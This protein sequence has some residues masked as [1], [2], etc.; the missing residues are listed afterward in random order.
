MYVTVNGGSLWQRR[1]NGLP[2]AVGTLPRSAII[3]YGSSTEFFVGLG[4][5]TNTGIG[6]FRTT[7]QG[8]SW[9]D[10][11]GGV[12]LNSY[13]IRALDFK[14]TGDTTIF[15]GGAHPTI[16]TGQGVFE[17][18]WPPLGI[19]DPTLI[20]SKFFLEQNYPNPFNPNTVIK[21]GIPS[22]SFVT[23]KVYDASGSEVRTLVNEQKSPGYY[24]ISFG[25][26][27]LSSGVYFYA[28]RAGDFIRTKKMILIK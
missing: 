2:N 17:Y 21:F 1:H 9:S 19:S 13:T 18:S 26:E 16:T 22:Q 20:P 5:A 25:G 6:V 3:R 12:M 27:G 28:I 23:I 14:T 24:E 8:L 11:N 10:F 4:N 15:A 7:N